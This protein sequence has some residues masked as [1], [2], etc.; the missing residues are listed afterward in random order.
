[1][2]AIRDQVTSIAGVAPE[3]RAGAQV[4]SEGENWQTTVTGTTAEWFE[5]RNW[6]LDSGDTFTHADVSG[7]RKVAIL[8]KTVVT[9]LYGEGS[10][11]VGQ[12]VRINR[13]PFT[14]I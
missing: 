13:I 1:M 2:D 11:P 10:D 12:T 5:I 4:M 3:L 7:G 6:P 14:V 9:N 8:G